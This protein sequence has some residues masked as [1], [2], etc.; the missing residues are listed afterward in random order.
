MSVQPD[1]TGDGLDGAIVLTLGIGVDGALENTGAGLQDR[2]GDG[3]QDDGLTGTCLQDG[4]TGD[5]CTG[6][7]DAR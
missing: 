6:T 7:R 4:R 5:A 3:L 1:H 2:R